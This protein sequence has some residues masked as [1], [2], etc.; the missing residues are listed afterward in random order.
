M[1]ANLYRFCT[2]PIKDACPRSGG[3]SSTG[4]ARLARLEVWKRSIGPP[5]IGVLGRHRDHARDTDEIGGNFA[6]EVLSTGVITASAR[7]RVTTVH[8]RTTGRPAYW[9]N[10][11]VFAKS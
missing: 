1:H 7:K 3:W 6:V 10:V 2:R 11:T 8:S 4:S 9:S 5:V